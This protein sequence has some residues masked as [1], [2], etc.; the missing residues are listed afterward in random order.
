MRY[1]PSETAL[2]AEAMREIVEDA[3][4]EETEAQQIQSVLEHVAGYVIGDILDRIAEL[5]AQGVLE[6]VDD[7]CG[8]L[9][10]LC[11]DE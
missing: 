10:H 1:F 2:D 7:V 11:D 9:Y 6:S 5:Q 4:Q 8:Y 3:A